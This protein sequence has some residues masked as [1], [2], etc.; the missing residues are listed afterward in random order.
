MIEDFWVALLQRMGKEAVTCFGHHGHVLFERIERQRTTV[1]VVGPHSTREFIA[2]A[3]VLE[4]DQALQR[5]VRDGGSV[6]A[7]CLCIDLV[8]S[9]N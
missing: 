8:R 4:F 2:D 3:L 1:L 9:S 6:R 7:C 5:T